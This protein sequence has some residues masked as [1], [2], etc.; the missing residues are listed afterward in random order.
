MVRVDSYVCSRAPKAPKVPKENLSDHATQA[1]LQR[2]PAEVDQE[3]E[4]EVARLQVRQH[5]R[6]VVGPD[7]L[8]D[9]QLDDELSAYQQIDPV[10][11][12]GLAL[13]EHAGPHL[14]FELDP[15]S[16]KLKHHRA[17]V[18]HLEVART[19]MAMDF[20]RGADDASR[21]LLDVK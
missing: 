16:V 12:N 7:R 15:A 9:L 1:G 14:L 17:L 11:T 20:D 13:V 18:D 2:G 8:D 5:L 3:S 6:D 21:E 4:L 10:I 19:E